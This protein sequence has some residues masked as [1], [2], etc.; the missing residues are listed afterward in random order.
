MDIEFSKVLVFCPHPD[1]GEFS[2]GGAMAKWASEGKEV[3]LCVVTNGAAGSNDPDVKRDWLIETRIKEQK[4]AAEVTGLS[5]VIFLG[6]E[7]G[8]VEDSHELRRDMIR[9]IRRIKPDVVVGPD[10]TTF[11]FAQRY[12]NHP[13][14][15]K[16]GESFL[17]AVN[18]GAST[19]PLYREDLYDKGFG[20]HAIK[21][22]LLSFTTQPDYF[23]D[24]TDHID[25]KIKAIMTHVSQMGEDST[26]VD[27]LIKDMGQLLAGASGQ[28]FKYA[29]GYKLFM[30][31][32]GA[33]VPGD[34][35]TSA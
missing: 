6:Y 15:R 13:D 4:A 34:E 30:F 11:Y 32:S 23:V 21:A 9:E 20:P 22:C 33:G 18:P 28:G 27:G 25:T 16:V 35:E 29:E 8:A 3:I 12:V 1:D 5:D 31:D 7:D 19:V 26:R 17:A 2:A 10:P 14:H 24:I